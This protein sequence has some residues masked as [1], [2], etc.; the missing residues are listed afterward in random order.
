MNQTATTDLPVTGAADVRRA[1]E[2]ARTMACALGFDGTAGEEIAIVA[3]ELAANLVRHGG[4]GMLT[5]VPLA[6]AG[7]AGLR[8][9]TRNSGRGIADMERAMTDGHSTA[10]GLGCGLGA[11]NRLMDDLE[12]TSLPGQETRVSCW[13]WLR[14]PRNGSLAPRRIEFGAATRACRQAAANGDAFVF[15]AWENA[16]LAGV[17]DGLGHGE[18]AQRAAQAARQYVESHFDQPLAAIFRGVGRACRATR[19]VVMALARFDLAGGTLSYASVG[20][21]EP[22][23]LGG[24]V[25]AKF[26]LRR[27]IVGVSAV[28]PAVTAHPW[29]DLSVL[30]MHSDGLRLGWAWSDFPNLTR[31]PATLAS[32]RLLLGL[33]HGADDATVVVVKGV[34]A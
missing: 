9:E 30:V 24:P 14:P 27:G 31:E 3:S 32:R 6:E 20:N 11:V 18:P 34:A 5:V 4:G 19:G 7:R 26:I 2:T 8:I 12:I 17:I 22:R 29:D 33:D 28:E 15:K 23:L 13:R 16:A 25:P 10:G 1:Q 21:I